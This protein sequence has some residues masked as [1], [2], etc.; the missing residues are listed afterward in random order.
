MQ[1]LPHR[2]KV[3]AAAEIEENVSLSSEGL[4][5]IESA[6]PAEF[7]GPGDRWSPETLLLAAV[8]DCYILTFKAIARASKCDW[9]A[10]RCDVEG[11]LDRVDRVTRF[12]QFQLAVVLDVPAGTDEQAAMRILEKTEH[13]CLITNSMTVQ[14]HLNAE[15]R[16]ATA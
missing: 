15:V 14:S 8:A 16:S 6:A 13:A 5:T 9:S 10:I 4:E 12:T 3:A 1:A 11:T 7:G 2:Y